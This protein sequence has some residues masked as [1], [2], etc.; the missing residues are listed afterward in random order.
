MVLLFD[1]GVWSRGTGTTKCYNID[2]ATHNFI[3]LNFRREGR[4]YIPP[5]YDARLTQMRQKH[6]I[7][8]KFH[9]YGIQFARL[10]N[11]IASL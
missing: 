7:A 6:R 10:S 8:P 3:R 11:C 4:Y 1:L 5:K 9:R 2:E